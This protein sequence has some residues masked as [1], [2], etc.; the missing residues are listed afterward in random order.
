L[1]DTSEAIRLIELTSARL[2]Q[3]IGD[4]SRPVHAVLVDGAG[5]TP[6][7]G[8]AGAADGETCA[9]AKPDRDGPPGQASDDQVWRSKLRRAAWGPDERPL[10]YDELLRLK[11]G[12][13][14]G[15]TLDPSGLE[16]HCVFPS[17]IGRI[18]LNL[19]L[20]AADSLPSGGTVMLAGSTNDLFLRIVGPAAAWPAGMAACVV[21]E[22]TA[23]AA[24]TGD[25]GVQMTLTTLLAHASGIR[26]SFLLASS[27]QTTPPILRLGGN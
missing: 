5:G 16:N 21:D 4:P 10:S 9:P 17:R 7:E 1:P 6:S 20:L 19:L 8:V 22:A 18:V 23:R 12:L 26:L 13:P 11:A 14:A 25:R 24:M 27:S 3:D 2:C 15:V